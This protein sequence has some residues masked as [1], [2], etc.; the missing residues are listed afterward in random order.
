MSL[1][2]HILTE[3]DGVTWC[4]VRL[5][6]FSAGIVYHCAFAWMIFGQHTAVDMPLL[7]AYI[8]HLSTLAATCAAGV[9][10][11]SILKADA[12]SQP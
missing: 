6:L 5:C 4:P 3:P 11:K 10:A 8:Q 9:G 7:G 1:L 2:R 12:P